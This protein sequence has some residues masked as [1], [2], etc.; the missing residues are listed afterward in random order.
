MTCEDSQENLSAMMDGELAEEDLDSTLAHASACADCRQFLSVITRQP[1]LLRGTSPD[2]VPRRLDRRVSDLARL[3][4]PRTVRVPLQ[5]VWDML[6]ARVRIP[7]PV[8]I[9]TA[10]LLLGL[11][12]FSAAAWRTLHTKDS[13]ATRVVYMMEFPPVEVFADTP[14]SP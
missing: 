3:D 11:V 8:A 9:G 4:A 5:A 2:G 7:V 14:A 10:G 1:A 12:I 6:K 13:Q